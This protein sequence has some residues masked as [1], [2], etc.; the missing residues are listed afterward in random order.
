MVMLATTSREAWETL[1][2]SFVSQSTACVMQIRSALRK[3][4]K[5]DSTTTNFF[6]KVKS[7]A[8][9]MSSISQ[10]LRPKEFN[11]YLL[12]SLD[13]EYD[14]LAEHISS[15][16]LDDPMPIHDVFA[17]LLNTEQRVKSRR[18][19]IAADIHMAAHYSSR[20]KSERPLQFQSSPG[21]S[22][23]GPHYSPTPQ[24]AQRNDSVPQL[25]SG[26]RSCPTRGVG[27]TC[28]TCQICSKVGHMASRCF[29]R[30]LKN[31][32]GAGN[33][34]RNME[35]Q[36]AAF[37]ATNNGSTSSYPIDPAWYAD[38]AA[39]D[40]LTN[41]LDKLTM[42]DTMEKI[43]SKQPMAQVCAL[44]ILVNPSF[45]LHHTHYILKISFMFPL[46]LATFSQ[47]KYLPLTIMFSLNFILGIFL[48]RIKIRGRFFLE[49]DV[50]EAYTI[51][52]F[53]P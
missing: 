39:K 9:V 49:G 15:R 42:N 24:G 43:M 32:L 1:K 6:N 47:L 52:M 40:H 14:A 18:S 33:D 20:P 28:P 31:F 16:P 11:S 44:H 34:G 8:D 10:P 53:C 5:L 2:A 23:P 12:A 21:L 27:G 46:L 26:T 17:Q 22:N 45:L 7:M 13:K 3:V 50:V 19:E 37:S 51:S 38:T 48:L 41:N 29:K 25:T 35:H 30:Y 4:K 36:L